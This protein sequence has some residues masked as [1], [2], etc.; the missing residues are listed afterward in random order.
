MDAG[1]GSANTALMREHAYLAKLAEK[2]REILQ[3][4][5]I[6]NDIQQR[7]EDAFEKTSLRFAMV[8]PTVNMEIL[9][10]RQKIKAQDEQI[11]GLKTE[12]LATQFR[13]T[14][15]SGQKL[16]KKCRV[17]LE[18]NQSLGRQISEGP[19]QDLLVALGHERQQVKQLSERLKKA[20]KNEQIL[21]EENEKLSAQVESLTFQLSAAANSCASTDC[22]KKWGFLSVGGGG[23][24]DMKPEKNMADGPPRNKRSVTYADD[25]DGAADRKKGHAKSA[26][27]MSSQSKSRADEQE[28]DAEI[29]ED[30]CSLTL[31]STSLLDAAAR[32]AFL[33]TTLAPDESPFIDPTVE[34]T[35]LS[36]A[37]NYAEGRDMHDDTVNSAHQDSSLVVPTILVEEGNHTGGE[38]I[39]SNRPIESEAQLR[40]E[41]YAGGARPRD[42]TA[43]KIGNNQQALHQQTV[44]AAATHLPAE[45]D[46]LE[47][48]SVVKSWA[49]YS[50]DDDLRRL[51]DPVWTTV[52]LLDGTHNQTAQTGGT[53]NATLTDDGRENSLLTMTAEDT[54]SSMGQLTN[55][56]RPKNDTCD[57]SYAVRSPPRSPVLQIQSASTLSRPQSAPALPTAIRNL[58]D[59]NG[60]RKRAPHVQY[61]QGYLSKP[62]TAEA[63]ARGETATYHRA[64]DTNG[65]LR[66]VKKMLMKQQSSHKYD[67]FVEMITEREK[68]THKYCKR[69]DLME[70]QCFFNMRD[71]KSEGPNVDL[72]DYAQRFKRDR[73]GSLQMIFVFYARLYSVLANIEEYQI[74]LGQSDYDSGTQ[75]THFFLPYD[76]EKP[77]LTL[78]EIKDFWLDFRLCDHV[79]WYKTT[80]IYQC[81]NPRPDVDSQ[82]RI[83]LNLEEFIKFLVLI[84]QEIYRFKIPKPHKRV[85]TL[86]SFLQLHRW[87]TLKSHLRD[88]FRDHH[89]QKY[90]ELTDFAV[91]AKRLWLLTKADKRCPRFEDAD[92]FDEQNGCD[93]KR[94]GLHKYIWL[95]VEKEWVKFAEPSRR[96]DYSGQTHTAFLDCGVI[97]LGEI[98]HF[99]VKVKNVTNHMASFKMEPDYRLCPTF[100]SV[101]YQCPKG[102]VAQGGF[103]EGIV[104][105]QPDYVNESVGSLVVWQKFREARIPLYVKSVEMEMWREG[106]PY[107]SKN[108]A[109]LG[110]E[111]PQD[112]LRVNRLPAF[113]PPQ[114]QRA[115]ANNVAM[116]REIKFSLNKKICRNAEV[117]PVDAKKPD[118]KVYSKKKTATVGNRPQNRASVTMGNAGPGGDEFRRQLEMTTFSITDLHDPRTFGGRQHPTLDETA[119]GEVDTGRRRGAGAAGRSGLGVPATG[120]RPTSAASGASRGTVQ[121][122]Q[123]SRTTMQGSA[124][125]ANLRKRPLTAGSATSSSGRHPQPQKSQPLLD[126]NA[127]KPVSSSTRRGPLFGHA[128]DIPI[129]HAEAEGEDPSPKDPTPPSRINAWSSVPLLRLTSLDALQ[130]ERVLKQRRNDSVV[131]RSRLRQRYEQQQLKGGG[132]GGSSLQT[133]K[134]RADRAEFAWKG[135]V[136]HQEMQLEKLLNTEPKKM[137]YYPEAGKEVNLWIQQHGMSTTSA[138]SSEEQ[139]MRLGGSSRRSVVQSALNKGN[140]AAVAVGGGA[141]KSSTSAAAVKPPHAFYPE[142]DEKEIAAEKPA[143]VAAATQPKKADYME[144]KRL[145]LG[146]ASVAT[147]DDYTRS[148]DANPEQVFIC[149]GKSVRAMA[150]ELF[151]WGSG[152][153][154]RL[155]LGSLDD[156]ATPQRLGGICNGRDFHSVSC[157]WY[158]SA[159]TTTTGDLLMFGSNVTGCLGFDQEEVFTDSSEDESDN[160][161][162]AEDSTAARPDFDANGDLLDRNDPDYAEV[163]E[164]T[165]RRARREKRGTFRANK[166]LQRGSETYVPKVLKIPKSKVQIVQVSCGGD[167]I[168]AHTLALTRHGRLYAWGYGPA[169]GTGVSQ[170]VTRPTLVKQYY[171]FAS[172]TPKYHDLA[173]SNGVDEIQ[174]GWGMFSRKGKWLT[175]ALSSGGARAGLQILAPRIVKVCAGGSFS[176]A[177]SY[178]GQVFTWGLSAGGRL[179]FRTRFRAQLRPR[180][181]EAVSLLL[182]QGMEPSDGQYAR[183]T[184]IAAGGAFGLLLAGQGG[185]TAS[186]ARVFA[187][188]ENSKG[189]LGVGHLMDCYEPTLVFHSPT[190]SLLLSQICAGDAHA[191]ALDVNGTVYSWGALGGPATGHGFPNPNALLGGVNAAYSR[192]KLDLKQ[193]AAYLAEV[194]EEGGT[195]AASGTF[196]SSS[197]SAQVPVVDQL[198]TEEKFGNLDGID[199][200]GQMVSLSVQFRLRSVPFWWT[201]P[202]GI[203]H[204]KNVVKIEAGFSHSMALT[205][206]GLL[207]QWGAPQGANAFADAEFSFTKLLRRKLQ[208]QDGKLFGY[209][210]LEEQLAR[211]EELSS[212]GGKGRTSP[213][214]GGVIDERQLTTATA[215]TVTGSSSSSTSMEKALTAN[216]ASE[217]AEGSGSTSSSSKQNASASGAASSSSSTSF[218][219]PDRIRAARISADPERRAELHWVPRLVSG[220]PHCPLLSCENACAGGWHSM[221]VARYETQF[222]RKLADGKL[223]EFCDG[224]LRCRGTNIPVCAAVLKARLGT[225]QAGR[226]A[227]EWVAS[228]I[229]PK[230]ELAEEETL[231]DMLLQSGR[232]NYDAAGSSAA[233]GGL[234]KAVSAVSSKRSLSPNTASTAAPNAKVEAVEHFSLDSPKSATGPPHDVLF[235]SSEEEESEGE[236]ATARARQQQKAAR[237]Q[238]TGAAAKNLNFAAGIARRNVP[239]VPNISALSAAAVTVFLHFLYLDCLEFELIDDDD[240]AYVAEEASGPDGTRAQ[241]KLLVLSELNQLKDLANRLGLDRLANLVD[242]FQL[243]SS[244]SDNKNARSEL[245]PLHVAPSD[246]HASLRRLFVQTFDRSKIHEF[247]THHRLMLQHGDATPRATTAVLSQQIATGDDTT[248]TGLNC[249]IQCGPLKFCPERYRE[250]IFVEGGERDLIIAAHAAVLVGECEGCNLVERSLD[251]EKIRSPVHRA[252]LGEEDGEDDEGRYYLLDLSDFPLDV[253]FAGLS[254]I[255]TQEFADVAMPF[256]R[257]PVYSDENRVLE[258]FFYSSEELWKSLELVSAQFENADKETSE[259]SAVPDEGTDDALEQLDT[260]RQ[261]FLW[262][263]KRRVEWYMDL[264]LLADK[265]QATHLRRYVEDALVGHLS[266]HNWADL[267]VFADEKEALA[268]RD[269]ALQFGLRQIAPFAFLRGAVAAADERTLFFSH[270]SPW[271]KSNALEKFLFDLD[272]PHTPGLV[273]QEHFNSNLLNEVKKRRPVQLNELKERIVSLLVEFEKVEYNLDVIL[274]KSVFHSDND[275]LQQLV[276]TAKTSLSRFFFKSSGK[277]A[278]KVPDPLANPEKAKNAEKPRDKFLFGYLLVKYFW[279]FFVLVLSLLVYRYREWLGKRIHVLQGVRYF[280]AEILANAFVET[281]EEADFL[282]NFSMI[283][284]FHVA[285]Q[286][287]LV[288]YPWLAA[289]YELCAFVLEYFHEVSIAVRLNPYFIVLSMNVLFVGVTL[290]LYVKYI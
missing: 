143:A 151:T 41:G 7:F 165:R 244:T 71:Y 179:G 130:R 272:L 207:Y 205:K 257:P 248:N 121:R 177:L 258:Q 114:Y 251:G 8:D 112:N 157:S 99:K 247:L 97:E 262:S 68:M 95:N 222:L 85:Q 274:S 219:R 185:G 74:K 182:K 47:T 273:L 70:I 238:R 12:L 98:K 212:I 171:G 169:T 289:V 10:L 102:G 184:D 278:E 246:L 176:V 115:D 120:S 29:F 263:P 195:A 271:F 83:G 196:S 60:N 67:A 38:S 240:D 214:G 162:G 61:E 267:W 152:A 89:L 33:E 168:G 110:T 191:L 211:S 204:L 270:Q 13:P 140:S 103:V 73:P 54:L 26:T 243:S 127:G 81:V 160:S 4:K 9:R 116:R 203:P 2:D 139:D 106:D 255:Y 283:N 225:R 138:N 14:S 27:A 227:W 220:T 173:A 188:G 279:E 256:L 237:S 234:S 124:S 202:R 215:S 45:G 31:T 276:S 48:V 199:N 135:D 51:R 241:G 77:S 158:H 36:S 156:H 63:Q 49:E 46:R 284:T 208:K 190:K 150:Q 286:Q 75:A 280:G 149:E 88:C 232:R 58:I 55:A 209:E 122:G 5:A 92:F 194:E 159:C 11:D 250:K 254:F 287:T 252:V 111:I 119:E 178:D 268:L 76:M 25:Y 35:T 39:I 90:D 266:D 113:V 216:Y 32:N 249:L 223:T 107:P 170:T 117:M 126:Q 79:N 198:K 260:Y 235:T 172:S 53:L 224:F 282:R 125:A 57:S 94:F 128:F 163:E 264:F 181:L 66:D 105:V 40:G 15:V 136:D 193:Y 161:S 230:A 265:L 133:N 65:N 281:V 213:R 221:G 108:Y 187:F 6:S 217:T 148:F 132:G 167:M 1:I 64:L 137:L 118:K 37:A 218:M 28:V 16:M 34:T 129:R 275:D 82:N 22:F 80:Q 153:Y 147:P 164:R 131:S 146:D 24:Y 72:A 189:Q 96:F 197:S 233:D 86:V 239:A 269:A 3:Y 50:S 104:K 44:S 141:A 100:V 145:V 242:Q 123:M 228:Q 290:G 84:A 186:G 17:L 56:D 144:R 21:D 109:H 210:W 245:P 175:K 206:E 180:R 192:R 277:V 62:P 259:E 20:E 236:S 142:P 91:V 155:G 101:T 174:R 69:A 18:E 52:N 288:E 59:A 166:A 23:D 42:G 253:V 200:F 43:G 229:L 285:A 78:R 183:I 93:V 19:I 30:Q 201:R 261:K 231:C 226:G 154:G 134:S 87:D